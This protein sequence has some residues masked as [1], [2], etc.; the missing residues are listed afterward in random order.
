MYRENGDSAQKQSFH[1]KFSQRDSCGKNLSITTWALQKL[2]VVGTLLGGSDTNFFLFAKSVEWP[3][4]EWCFVAVVLIIVMTH[5]LVFEQRDSSALPFICRA[6]A[7]GPNLFTCKKKT[8]THTLSIFGNTRPF[9]VRRSRICVVRN[10]SFQEDHFYFK[11]QISPENLQP[12]FVWKNLHFT[13][14]TPDKGHQKVVPS[15]HVYPPNHWFSHYLV[16]TTAWGR[17][18]VPSPCRSPWFG[19]HSA[20][21]AFLAAASGMLLGQFGHVDLRP[22]WETYGKIVCL[23]GTYDG[24][25]APVIILILDWD[26]PF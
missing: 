23:V 3:P 7:S 18:W 4:L 20:S 8:H 14:K 22:T 21:W 13:G 26:F 1:A 12:Q 15:I 17:L 9:H 5:P 6:Y 19:C 10:I 2:G 11:T 24:F 25:R 16:M